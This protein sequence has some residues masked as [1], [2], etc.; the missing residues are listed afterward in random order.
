MP[1]N[2]KRGE[3][4]CTMAGEKRIARLS[5]QAC[6]WYRDMTGKDATTT[7]LETL[8]CFTTA[9]EIVRAE[10]IDVNSMQAALLILSE[11][12][13]KG[14]DTVSLMKLWFVSLK[15]CDSDLTIE[16]FMDSVM[17]VDIITDFMTIIP[18]L[19]NRNTPPERGNAP[20]RAKPA[21]K[22]KSR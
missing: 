2:A 20:A 11:F 6:E 14:F 10:G 18:D 7:L 3:V 22:R 9:A 21:A 15:T 16:E 1:A 5:G 17:P 8:R 19:L 12:N 4:E 13:L